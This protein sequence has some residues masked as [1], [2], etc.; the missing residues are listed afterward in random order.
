MKLVFKLFANLFA[1]LVGKLLF[2]ANFVICLFV[3][4]W[5]K[6]L[7][8]L[9]TPARIN[10]HIKQSG[11]AIDFCSSG[12]YYSPVESVFMFIAALV[13]LLFLPPILMT[14]LAWETSKDYTRCGV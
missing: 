4:D 14:E 10:C 2:V 12:F 3:F 9:E 8:Y 6:F 11:G 13:Y 7:R 1:G 5:S